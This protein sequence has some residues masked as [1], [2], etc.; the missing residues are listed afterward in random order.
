MFKISLTC[1]R[2]SSQSRR[3]QSISTVV[4]ATMKYSLKVMGHL[5]ALV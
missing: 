1:G 5:V 2:N 3:G 4:R